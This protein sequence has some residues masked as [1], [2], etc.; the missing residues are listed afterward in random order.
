MNNP[1]AASVDH[2]ALRAA[3]ARGDVVS[4]E[5]LL[6]LTDIDVNAT[7]GYGRTAL[8]LAVMKGHISAV[9]VLLARP[10]INTNALDRCGRTALI[11]AAYQGYAQIVR[12]LL[13]SPNT[14]I[15]IADAFGRT[16]LILAVWNDHV[17]IVQ[18]LLNSPG[19][20]V[21][22]A[23]RDGLTALAYARS[24]KNS[25]IQ[26]SLKQAFK[27]DS[28]MEA[29]RR[30]FRFNE[31]QAWAATMPEILG[32]RH[33]PLADRDVMILV[34]RY[35]AP[36]TYQEARHLLPFLPRVYGIHLLCATR[37]KIPKNLSFEQDSS[38][39]ALPKV[40]AMSQPC[41]PV[42]EPLATTGFAKPKISLEAVRGR[43]CIL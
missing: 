37:L 33:Q 16:A 26:L 39:G 15:N 27:R 20:K 23:D 17:V 36:L 25:A 4:L 43:C 21:K 42:S 11:L 2:A 1:S 8:T 24:G 7:D 40:V 28:L 14:N 12:A 32:L 22:V 35:L 19:I 18:N 34:M 38:R 5:K 13:E 10:G 31:A 6:A 29:Y 3:S 41:H 9:N 30:H